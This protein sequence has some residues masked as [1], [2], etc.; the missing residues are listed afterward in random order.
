MTVAGEKRNET[1]GGIFGYILWLLFFAIAGKYEK[2]ERC[3]VTA[4][5]GVPAGTNNAFYH[6]Q[7]SVC[8]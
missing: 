6:Q 7:N 1:P 5:I 8:K 2:N 4:F 3:A